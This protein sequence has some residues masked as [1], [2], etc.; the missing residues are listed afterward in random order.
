[1]GFLLKLGSW[2]HAQA[3]G[4]VRLWGACLEFGQREHLFT[5][6]RPLPLW[7]RRSPSLRLSCNRP[8][9]TPTRSSQGKFQN[10][11]T[12]GLSKTNQGPPQELEWGHFHSNNIGSRCFF[13]RNSGGITRKRKRNACWSVNNKSIWHLSEHQWPHRCL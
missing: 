3:W 4:L 1:M 9:N 8:E 12:L 13:Y 2:G 5:T 7:K 10:M 6:S 11:G